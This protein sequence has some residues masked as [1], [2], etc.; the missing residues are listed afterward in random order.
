MN[1]V[2]EYGG[3]HDL[4][5]LSYGIQIHTEASYLAKHSGSQEK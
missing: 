2:N 1:R 5:Y 4:F 3:L